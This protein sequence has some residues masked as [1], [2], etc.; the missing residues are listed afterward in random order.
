MRLEGEQ[1]LYFTSYNNRAFETLMQ[2]KPG[3][4][5]FDSRNSDN[6]IDCKYCRYHRP[7]WKYEF[8]IFKECPYCPG[9]YTRK[10]SKT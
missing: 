8:C 4:D 1:Q 6:G 9:K 5:R 2:E 10:Y 3:F 7:Y